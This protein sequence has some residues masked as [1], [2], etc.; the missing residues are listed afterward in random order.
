M[1]GQLSGC[2]TSKTFQYP[3]EDSTVIMFCSQKGELGH[4][5]VNFNIP[6]DCAHLPVGGVRTTDTIYAELDIKYLTLN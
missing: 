1:Q 3:L 6:D 2:F 4:I 5:D